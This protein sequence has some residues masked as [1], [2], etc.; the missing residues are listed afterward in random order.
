VT[1]APRDRRTPVGCPPGRPA[2]N[3]ESNGSPAH[4]YTDFEPGLIVREM[5]WQASASPA[6]VEQM[7]DA[8]GSLWIGQKPGT[9]SPTAS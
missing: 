2:T 6:V 9:E 3:I 1:A 8:S 4:P 7:R 5:S